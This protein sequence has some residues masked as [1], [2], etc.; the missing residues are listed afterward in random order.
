[1]VKQATEASIPIDQTEVTYG[2]GVYETVKI[3][4]NTIYFLPQHIDRLMY[5]AK[6]ITLVHK[7]T[8]DFVKEAMYN[9]I[10]HT[11]E[12]SCNI[13]VLLYGAPTPELTQLYILPSAPLYPDRKWYRDGVSLTAYEHERWMPQA[14]TLNMLPSYVMY[15]KAKASGHYDALLYNHQGHIC[16]GTRTNVYLMKGKSIFSPQKKDVLEGV[17]MMSLEKVISQTDFSIEYV[18]VPMS[19]LNN[20]DG[21][22]ISST[23]TKIM[24]VRCVDDHTFPGISEDLQALIRVYDKA[25]DTCAGDFDKL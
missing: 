14:K 11:G 24:P 13:K 7:F 19:T 20:Y 3:R 6:Q 2:F 16:E 23:S 17:T 10:P 15:K 9:L 5:S 22:F 4:N 1:M 18:D 12:A 8:S 21:M 25:L